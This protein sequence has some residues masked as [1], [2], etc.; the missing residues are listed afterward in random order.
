MK[1]QKFIAHAGYC[2]RRKA[3][4]LIAQGKV[5]VNGEV[6]HIGQVVAIES[7]V[8][9]VEE[10][11]IHAP[12]TDHQYYLVYKPVGV[13]STTSDELGRDTV[14]T[15]IPKT[16]ARLYPVGRLDIDSEGLMLLTDDGDLAYKLTHP[17]FEH[18]KTYEALVEGNPS[19]KALEHLRKGVKLK[20]GF[21]SPA[22]VEFAETIADDGQTWLELSIHEGKY[23]QVRRMLERV[24]YPVLELVRTK[25]GPWTLDDLDGEPYV[26]L[27]A[28]QVQQALKT[29]SE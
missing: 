5:T 1:L 28:E 2:S 21:T 20:E 10:T 9:E 11:P 16:E 6:A 25:F 17:K 29:N 19:D 23:H 26:S 7:D 24:G 14:L 22:E 8:I 15:L 13:V 12:S 3:E 18:Q 27:T 4:E